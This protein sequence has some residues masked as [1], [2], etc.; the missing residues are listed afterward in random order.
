M[1]SLVSVI[2][3]KRLTQQN[4]TVGLHQTM[5]IKKA[6]FMTLSE[7]IALLFAEYKS[8]EKNEVVELDSA[9]SVHICK[10]IEGGAV[11][12]VEQLSAA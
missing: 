12:G 6:S 9:V 5:E 4:K 1:S 3:L 11:L 8:C 2:Y 10:L 7:F